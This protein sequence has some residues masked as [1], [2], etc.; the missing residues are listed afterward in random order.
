MTSMS[1][2]QQVP[3]VFVQVADV[4]TIAILQ[5]R[6]LGQEQLEKTQLQRALSSRIVIEQAKHPRRTLERHPPTPRTKP[7]APTH[8][9]TSCASPN[10]HATSSTRPWTPT[11]FPTPDLP[12]RRYRTGPH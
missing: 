11:A 8:G 4:A 6:D 7:C 5:Q 9:R 3:K 12:G 10:A 1:R 2:E